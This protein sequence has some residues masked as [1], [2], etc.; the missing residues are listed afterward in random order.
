[1]K[2]DGIVVL[3]LLLVNCCDADA[4]KGEKGAG[5]GG[6]GFLRLVIPLGRHRNLRRTFPSFIITGGAGTQASS[7]FVFAN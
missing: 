1:M 2:F 5:G 4:R 7:A 3:P 6:G